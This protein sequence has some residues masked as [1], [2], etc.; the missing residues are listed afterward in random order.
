MLLPSVTGYAYGWLSTRS[1]D[2]V[3]STTNVATA[4][5]RNDDDGENGPALAA[6]F[7]TSDAGISTNP[8]SCRPPLGRIDAANWLLKWVNPPLLRSASSASLNSVLP[9]NVMSTLAA[10]V[11]IVR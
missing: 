5:I 1:P 4:S 8:P 10:S 6:T 2:M 3:P 9:G 11:T 7:S